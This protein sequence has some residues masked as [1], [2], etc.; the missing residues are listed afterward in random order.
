MVPKTRK[1]KLISQM[2]TREGKLVAVMTQEG[3]VRAD[4]RDPSKPAKP[5]L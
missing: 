2:Y 4:I 1:L 5:K 3:V